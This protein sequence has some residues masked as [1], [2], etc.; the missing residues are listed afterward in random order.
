MPLP[1][2]LSIRPCREEDLPAVVDML[3]AVDQ[4][5]GTIPWV[6]LSHLQ[7]V[8]NEPNLDREKDT[9]IVE[10]AGRVVAYAD[11]GVNPLTGQGQAACGVHPDFKAQGIGTYLIEQTE[12]RI[13]DKANAEAA[14]ETPISVR[15]HTIHLNHSAVQLFA[16]QGYRHVRDYYA[17]NIALDQPFEVPPLPDGLELRPFNAERDTHAVYETHQETFQDH[18]DFQRDLFEEWEHHM[19]KAPHTDTSLWLIA[20]ANDEIAGIALSSA[21]GVGSTVGWVD[22]LGVRRPWRKRG[23]GTALLRRSF[24]RLQARG[25]TEARLSVDAASLTNAAALYER[26]G[27]HVLRRLGAYHKMLRGDDPEPVT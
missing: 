10:A 1:E 22:A 19:L 24:A 9:F 14:P 7:S 4:A 2:N 21:Y 25:F 27:M 20:Y 15:R 11:C 23:L 13:R 3:H 6:M 18:W 5:N 16:Q 8:L 12:Q 26:A 17:M